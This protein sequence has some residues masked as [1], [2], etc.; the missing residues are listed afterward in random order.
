[1]QSTSDRPDDGARSL[2]AVDMRL[3]LRPREVLGDVAGNVA[4][5]HAI[6]AVASKTQTIQCR[7]A[8]RIAPPRTIIRSWR[9]ECSGSVR[10]LRLSAPERAAISGVDLDHQVTVGINRC[11]D[12]FMTEPPHSGQLGV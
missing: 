8:A 11:S 10:A 5:N 2:Q 1:M 7:A 12:G 3:R 6:G 9:P 4:L